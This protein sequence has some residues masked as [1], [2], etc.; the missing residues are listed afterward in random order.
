M[1]RRIG[2][3]TVVFTARPAVISSASVAGKSE[4]NGPFG[5]QFDVTFEDDRWGEK[6]YELAERKMLLS[7]IETAVS[8]A[9]FDITK[10]DYLLG[11]DLLNQIISIGFAARQLGTPFFGLYGACSTMAESLVLGA[12]ITDGGFAQNVV[13]A[14]SSHFATAERQFRMPL[15]LG[16]PKTPTSQN[17]ATAA[18]AVV[19]SANGKG[20]PVVTHATAGSVV[21]PG[22]NDVNNMG[23]AMAP[24]AAQTI[25]T[26]LEDTGRSPHDY[27]VIVTGD[28]GTFGSEMLIELCSQNGVDLSATHQDCGALIYGGDPLMH[29]GG[30]GCGCSASMLCGHFLPKLKSGQMRRILFVATGALHS[31]TSALQGETVPGIAHAVVIESEG[32]Q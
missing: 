27:D 24:A 25:L 13:C 21:D 29:C 5:D 16:T 3:K 20:Q 17:T 30:S 7:A 8:N 31:P 14:T 32:Q 1:G 19:L 12:M 6:T 4:K 26:H 23:A 10:I 11:G 2:Q 28:L 22:I 15:E 18:G 9:G